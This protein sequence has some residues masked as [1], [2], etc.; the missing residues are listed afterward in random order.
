LHAQL[1]TERL[2]GPAQRRILP[3]RRD[4]PRKRYQILS[5]LCSALD[6]EGKEEELEEFNC[7]CSHETL[8]MKCP[9]ELYNGEQEVS[10]EFIAPGRVNIAA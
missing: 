9:A 5:N 6:E 4:P 3:K 1:L 8:S 10:F 7:E 2:T